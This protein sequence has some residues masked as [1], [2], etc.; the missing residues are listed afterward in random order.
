MYLELRIFWIAVWPIFE[1]ETVF[2]AFCWYCFDCGTVALR[3]LFFSLGVLGG[4]C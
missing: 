1:K 4:K 3:A 2:F